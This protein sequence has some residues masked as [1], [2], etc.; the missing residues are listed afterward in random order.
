MRETTV[1]LLS[2]IVMSRA[3]TFITGCSFSVVDLGAFNQTTSLLIAF[4]D[5]TH[6][7]SRSFPP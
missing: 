3:A 6:L 4:S 1:K 2:I 5:L 7:F